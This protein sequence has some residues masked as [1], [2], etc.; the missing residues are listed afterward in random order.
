M[1][2]PKPTEGG[3]F[4]PAPAGTFLATCYRFIDLGTHVSEYNGERKTRHEVLLSWELADELMQDGRPFTVNKRYTWS[5][6]EKATLRLHLEAWRG[7]KFEQSDFEGDTAFNTKKLIGVPC[8]ITTT[9][10]TKPDGKVI[11]KVAGVGKAIRGM[12]APPLVNEPVYIAL[13]REGFDAEAYGKLSDYFRELISTSPE[14][15][16]IFASR[17]MSDDPPPP[18]GYDGPNDDVPF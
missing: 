16:D 6:H 2:L 12:Q 7:K 9:Q 17:R 5:M 14:Y 13:D 11:A 8:T 18:S 4:A 1:Q 10:E 15:K 3:D